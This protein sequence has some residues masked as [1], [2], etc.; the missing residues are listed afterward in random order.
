MLPLALPVAISTR[1]KLEAI[2][3]ELRYREHVYPRMIHRGAITQA[4][5]DRQIAI[6]RGIAED[7][8]QQF[9]R[10]RGKA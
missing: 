9:A 6:M 4:F 7:Y 3:R 10:E 2:E 5:A 1:D 8:R